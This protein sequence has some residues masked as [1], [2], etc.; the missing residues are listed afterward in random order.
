MTQ[1]L[2][3]SPKQTNSRFRLVTRQSRSATKTCVGELNMNR[4]SVL[5]AGGVAKKH[6]FMA[7]LLSIPRSAPVRPPVRHQRKASAKELAPMLQLCF[8]TPI[9]V[10]AR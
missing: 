5:A 4:T 1:A 8:P 9:R 3:R 2:Q 10:R 6:L 7:A